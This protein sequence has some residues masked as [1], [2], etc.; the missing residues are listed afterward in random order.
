MLQKQ[1][2]ID[3]KK[4]KLDLKDTIEK[5]TNQKEEEK[6]WNKFFFKKFKLKINDYIQTKDSF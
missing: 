2:L 6:H 4:I 3:A 1:H 5:Q